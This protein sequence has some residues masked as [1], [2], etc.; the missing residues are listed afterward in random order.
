MALMVSWL[1]VDYLATAITWKVIYK[2]E[3]VLTMYEK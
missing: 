2:L 1:Q 3:D